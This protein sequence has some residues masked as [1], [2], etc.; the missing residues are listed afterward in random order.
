MAVSHALNVLS[1]Q[2][3]LV[4]AEVPPEW[5]WPLNDE[6]EAWFDA[7]EAQRKDRYGGD[8][9]YEDAPDMMGNELARGRR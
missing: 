9:D 7:V 1:W 5:M 3:N 2:E 8:D 6:L 4:D